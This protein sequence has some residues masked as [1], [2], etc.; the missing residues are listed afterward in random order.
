[1]LSSLLVEVASDLHKQGD[2]D[3]SEYFVNETA[4][5]DKEV[6]SGVLELS[7]GT[8]PKLWPPQ[9]LLVFRSPLVHEMLSSTKAGLSAALKK[10][11]LS[12]IS[13]VAEL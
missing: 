6:S 4:P 13:S 9:M 2:V 12:P 8:S 5:P 10:Q 11:G 1:M 7:V 3:L